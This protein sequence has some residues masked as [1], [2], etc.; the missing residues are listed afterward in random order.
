[1]GLVVNEATAN[2]LPV[3]VSN[4]CG[5]AMDLVKDGVNGFTFDPYNVEEMAQAMFQLSACQPSRLSEMGDA[6]RKI[7]SNWG[8]ERFT[9]RLKAAAE[10]APNVGPKM[11]SLLDRVLLAAM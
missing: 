1:V 2:G 9:Q 5:C 3:L 8:P 10:C 4:R 7:I 11:V 6:S